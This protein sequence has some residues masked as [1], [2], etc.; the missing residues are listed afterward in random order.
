MPLD[1]RRTVAAAFVTS[2]ARPRGSFLLSVALHNPDLSN[3][4]APRR[5]LSTRT[6][7]VLMLYLST[8][9]QCVRAVSGPAHANQ[10][11][12]ATTGADVKRCGGTEGH[13]CR[14]SSRLDQIPQHGLAAVTTASK[15]EEARRDGI[16]HKVD[17]IGSWRER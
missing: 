12:G 5:L 2:S 15:L 13:S 4:T 9:V 10:E 7:S 1:W 14:L 16:Q 17:E 3:D 6:F 11:A 8:R